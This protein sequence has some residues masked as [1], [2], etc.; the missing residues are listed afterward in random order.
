MGRTAHGRSRRLL[1]PWAAAPPNNVDLLEWF[2][3]DE[4]ELC[5][6]CGER[7]CVGFPGLEAAFCLACNA[8]R[9]DGETITLN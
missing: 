9:I 2:S 5:S 3:E 7:A 8:V 4:R 6:D 1:L